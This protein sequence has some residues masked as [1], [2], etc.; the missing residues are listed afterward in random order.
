MSE[1]GFVTLAD[2]NEVYAQGAKLA[3][4]LQLLV[5]RQYDRD[6]ASL[7]VLSA[8]FLGVGAA[9]VAAVA[10]VALITSRHLA[11]RMDAVNM[12]LGAAAD[13]RSA[14]FPRAP[15]RWGMK[16]TRWQGTARAFWRG[17]RNL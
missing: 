11:Q 6:Q 4:D 9:I 13:G 14:S 7:L 15:A 5:A 3:P 8:V 2:G 1:E 17:R 12:A 10:L 16:L